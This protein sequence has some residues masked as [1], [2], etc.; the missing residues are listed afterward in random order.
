[1]T[2]NAGSDRTAALAG[3]SGG[4]V[5]VAEGK[6][7]KALESFLRP[8]FINRVDEIITFRSLDESDFEQIASIMLGELKLALAEKGMELIWSDAA[9]QLIAKESYSRKFGARNMRRYIQKEVEDALA[10]LII[11]DYQKSYTVA[12]IDAKD[13]KIQISCM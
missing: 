9:L 5:D 10:E 2:T 3:F 12:K 7:Q 6:T 13:D 8:E 1:M 4:E 11:A